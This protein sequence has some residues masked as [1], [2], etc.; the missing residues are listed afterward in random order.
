MTKFTVEVTEKQIKEI[1]DDLAWRFEEEYDSSVLKKV[2]YSSRKALVKTILGHEQF[3][4]ALEKAVQSVFDEYVYDYG[5]NDEMCESTNLPFMNEL[6]ERADKIC[7]E[8][9]TDVRANALKEKVAQAKK[10]LK[11]EGYAVSKV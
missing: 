5:L 1:A 7:E 10:L 8:H 9:L 6:Y 3:Q 11:A 4:Q 2:G